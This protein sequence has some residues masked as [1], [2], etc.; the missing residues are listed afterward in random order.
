MVTNSFYTLTT[1]VVLGIHIYEEQV[2]I[3]DNSDSSHSA[4]SDNV[5]PRRFEP[6]KSNKNAQSEKRH[7]RI[8]ITA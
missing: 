6:P 8:L 5:V 1:T 4:T 3:Y 7:G 2:A